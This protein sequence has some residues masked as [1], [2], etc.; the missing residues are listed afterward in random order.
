MSSSSKNT[1]RWI[2]RLSATLWVIWGAVHVFAG[3]ITLSH[4]ASGDNAEAFHGILS[5]L[6]LE[7]LQMDYP[8]GVM[9]LVQQH[10]FNLAWF[11]AVTFLCAPFVWR[12][13]RLAV[14]L[15]A[16]VG[17]LADLG[18]FLFIDLGGYAT[19]PGPQM[20]YICASAIVLGFVGLK[21]GGGQP[22]SAASA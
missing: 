22:N 13:Q 6:D 21:L 19:P 15:A 3:V 5:A 9:A 14:Y 7:S 16:L 4:I 20:T 11:G 2:L 18:Y 8:D 17:G 1:A 12:A 10:A